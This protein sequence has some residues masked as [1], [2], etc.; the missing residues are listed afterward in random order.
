[1]YE[2]TMGWACGQDG[3]DKECVHNFGGETSWNTSAWKA[4]KGQGRW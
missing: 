4:E 3:S 2:A 1:M